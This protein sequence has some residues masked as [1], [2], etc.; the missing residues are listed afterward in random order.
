[1]KGKG[2]FSAVEPEQ[3][4]L[5]II[6]PG[7]PKQIFTGTTK[8]LEYTLSKEILDEDVTWG[9]LERLDGKKRRWDTWR[10]IK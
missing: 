4:R 5:Y 2:R 7:M 8:Q 9:Q 10:S 1:M 3:L 6:F